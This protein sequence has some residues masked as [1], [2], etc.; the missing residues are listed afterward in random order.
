[1]VISNIRKSTSGSIKPFFYFQV[2]PEDFKL[3]PKTYFLSL[4]T[5]LD[6]VKEFKNNLLAK[7]GNHISFIEIDQVVKEIKSI[8]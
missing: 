3:F 1:L 7:T 5:P 6:K 8:S 4:F 2:Y